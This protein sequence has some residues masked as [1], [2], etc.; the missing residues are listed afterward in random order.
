MATFSLT[1]ADTQEELLGTIN[2]L[3]A[4]LTP[5]PPYVGNVL[6]ANTNTG[7]IVSVDT[8]GQPD[9]V[10]YI[11]DYI[12]VK[13]SDSADGSVNFTNVP[14]NRQYFGIRN[15]TGASISNN[16]ADYVWTQVTGGFGTTKFLYYLPLGGNKISFFAGTS[17][18]T[19]NYIQ[20]QTDT[21]I[22]LASPANFI[23]GTNNVIADAITADKIRANAVT[24]DKIFANA[25]IADK[26]AANAITS[27]KILANAV[28]ADKIAAGSIIA[29]KLAAV[30]VIT[31]SA[32]IANAIITTAKIGVAQ[33][34]T[35]RIGTNQVTV[36]VSTYSAAPDLTLTGGWYNLYGTSIASS[37]QPVTVIASFTIER[38]GTFGTLPVFY[39]RIA[40]NSSVIYDSFVSLGFYDNGGGA[41]GVATSW[42]GTLQDT[43]P[44][45]TNVYDLQI[46]TSQAL[47]TQ[48]RSMVLIET[49]R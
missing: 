38:S 45:G 12:N 26:I 27:D 18:P 14:T 7:Q 23:V 16:P 34:D 36:P 43:P 9:V 6:Y 25:V 30:D 41:T 47:Y 17:N 24:S 33:I 15:S 39:I 21:F 5:S 42:A 11:Y 1:S 3:L 2:Y 8:T 48:Y 4:N 29:S 31:S 22:F 32:Q 37:G 13:Y 46:F 35:L 44:A 20:T 40:R 19:V 28:I 49:K 10:S